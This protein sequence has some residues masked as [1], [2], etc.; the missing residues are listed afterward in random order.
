MC[1]QLERNNVKIKCSVNHLLSSWYQNSQHAFGLSV[2]VLT[3]QVRVLLASDHGGPAKPWGLC[4]KRMYLNFFVRLI[5]GSCFQIVQTALCV[6]YKYFKNS[7]YT[8]PHFSYCRYKLIFILQCS[9]HH[10]TF[11]SIGQFCLVIGRST[12]K[13]A[14]G[15][16]NQIMKNGKE[17]IITHQR[18]RNIS[19]TYPM[20]NQIWFHHL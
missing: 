10:T 5:F 19:E 18:N 1:A 7:E 8:G 6:L 17:N 20:L 4:Y 12:N 15:L 2:E 3:V 9:E 13:T 14:E 16:Y 11:C